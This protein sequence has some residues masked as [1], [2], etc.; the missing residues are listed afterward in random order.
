MIQYHTK[1]TPGI[2]K[3]LLNYFF[4]FSLG[5]SILSISIQPAARVIFLKTVHRIM[6]FCSRTFHGSSLTRAVVPKVCVK[7]PQAL[8]LTHTGT[9]GYFKYLEETKKSVEYSVY[10]PKVLKFQ[11]QIGHIAFDDVIFCQAGLVAVDM[12]KGKYC[13]KNTI[14]QKRWQC[15]VLFQSLE[16]V[17]CPADISH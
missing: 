4:V 7:A 10:Q 6:S 8:Q 11:H 16:N 13:I 3:S 5:I 14:K 12:M 1:F 17:Q 2:L 15:S 9:M